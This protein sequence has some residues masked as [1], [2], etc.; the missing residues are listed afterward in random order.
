[1]NTNIPVWLRQNDIIA[2]PDAVSP[3]RKADYLHKTLADIQHVLAEDMYAASVAR[4][5]GVLQRLDPCVKVLGLLVLIVC[6]ALS[7][8]LPALVMLN[9]FLA[10]LAFISGIR[11]GAYFYRVWLPTLMFVGITML[12]AL[13]S[14]ITPGEPVLV[15]WRGLQVS[16]GRFALPEN[17]SITRQGSLAAAFVICRAAASLGLVT[18]LV[19]TTPW[20][21]ITKAIHKLGV[22][23]LLVMVLDVTYRYLFLFL[24]LLSDYL[25]G[26]R[27]RLVGVESSRGKLYWVGGTIAGFFRIS[28][29]YSREVAYALQCRGYRPGAIGKTAI[30][31]TW[32]EALFLA[33]IALLGLGMLGGIGI[34]GTF[35]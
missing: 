20:T 8:D 24:F 9:V 18:L 12:P 14:W 25:L 5:Q 23:E 13:F 1:M 16:V 29:E 35:I 27:S 7:R 22:P 11:P 28:M 17:L 10:V 3:K 34:A 4:K 19:K 2:L 33:I 15:L 32:Q 21:L 26:R 6:A 31:L 30:C